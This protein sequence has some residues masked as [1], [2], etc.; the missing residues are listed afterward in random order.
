MQM[1]ELLNKKGGGVV[2]I[3]ETR[4]TGSCFVSFALYFHRASRVMHETRLL[5]TRA[6]FMH[7]NLK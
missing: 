2:E 4:C 7:E 5:S 6:I 1:L 3:N